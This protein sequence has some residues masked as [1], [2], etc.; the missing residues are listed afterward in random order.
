MKISITEL[1]NEAYETCEEYKMHSKQCSCNFICDM[2]GK[3]IGYISH[4]RN[5]KRTR[6]VY[7]K[8]K[9]D[10]R[11]IDTLKVTADLRKIILL[12]RMVQFKSSIFTPRLVV[13]NETMSQLGKHGTDTAV[14]W[15]EAFA[16]SKDEDIASAFYT[17]I[18]ILRDVKALT[19]GMDNCTGQNKNWTFYS[20]LFSVVNDQSIDVDEIILK[21]FVVGHTFMASDSAYGRIEKEMR[22]LKYDFKD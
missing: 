19:I 20:I 18:N 3:L 17:W 13:F 8:D 7:T 2:D 6:R 4:K 15:H 9:E 1:G 21:C 14:I 22:K 10:V 5:A 16:D 12:P 11:K